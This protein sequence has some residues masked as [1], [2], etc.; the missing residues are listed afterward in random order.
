MATYTV[1]LTA[2][3][4]AA[5]VDAVLVGLRVCRDGEYFQFF[6]LGVTGQQLAVADLSDP[7]RREAFWS[8]AIVAAAGQIETTIRDG[9]DGLP[10]PNPMEAVRLSVDVVSLLE[11][12]S[13]Q[14]GIEVGEIVATFEGP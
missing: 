8:A 2:R 1:E 6:E 9:G 3:D 14:G 12:S 7:A 5:N 11:A 10:R 13:G 4:R